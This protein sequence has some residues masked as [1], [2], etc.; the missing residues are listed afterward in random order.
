MTS[1]PA[2]FLCRDVLINVLRH[3]ETQHPLS[4]DAS[5]LHDYLLE[6][7]GPNFTLPK[8]DPYVLPAPT[9]DTRKMQRWCVQDTLWL[10]Q[11]TLPYPLPDGDK[12][13]VWAA[14]DW[15]QNPTEINRKRALLK[16]NALLNNR[17]SRS[18]LPADIAFT[19]GM[20]PWSACTVAYVNVAD[21]LLGSRRTTTGHVKPIVA[22]LALLTDVLPDMPF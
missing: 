4:D 12:Q 6:K 18:T 1:L 3:L 14:Q 20:F 15:L 2:E 11:D 8:L 22:L 17:A 16:G 9:A 13:C 5:V 21:N 7:H 19:A 10:V